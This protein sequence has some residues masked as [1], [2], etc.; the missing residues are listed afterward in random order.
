MWPLHDAQAGLQRIKESASRGLTVELKSQDRPDAKSAGSVQLYNKSYALVIGIDHYT[1]GWPPLSNAVRDAKMVADALREKGF[2]VTFKQD[3]NSAELKSALEEFHILKGADPQ[4]RLFVWYAGHGHTLNGEGY[5]A[6]ADAPRPTDNEALF[7]LRALSLRNFGV[8]VRSAVSKHV[9]AV[10]DSCFSGTIFSAQRSLPPAAITRA[11]TEPVRQFISSGDA[12]QEVS[13]DGLF[14][15]VF[16]DALQGKGSADANRDGYLTGSELGL[17]L[18][19]RLTNLSNARQ[20]PRYGKLRDRRFD[21]GDFVFQ[22]KLAPLPAPKPPPPAATPP[23]SAP[24]DSSLA[25]EAERTFWESVHAEGD[26]A[27]YRAY[28]KQYPKGYYASLARI[29][30]RKA[31]ERARAAQQR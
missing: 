24:R 19:D 2:E 12:K 17:F 9:M 10:F 30:I 16:L 28:L 3:L 23:S 4:A 20:T 22:V 8:Y 18:T 21:Q 11:V 7:K 15:Q 14:R 5:L 6:P 1:N 26:P 29:F 25:A 27:L 13:D 31:E